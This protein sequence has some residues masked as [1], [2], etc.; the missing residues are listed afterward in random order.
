[1][2]TSKLEQTNWISLFYGLQLLIPTPTLE[3]IRLVRAIAGRGGRIRGEMVISSGPIGCW[4]R[5]PSHV[6]Q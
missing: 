4:L 6:I 1:M 5:V 2:R 3:L